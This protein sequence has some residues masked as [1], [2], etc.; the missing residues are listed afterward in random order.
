MRSWSLRLAFCR[1]RSPDFRC[2]LTSSWYRSPS[3]PSVTT[4]ARISAAYQSRLRVGGAGCQGCDGAGGG[5]AGG[6]YGSTG[7][8]GYG[9]GGSDGSPAAGGVSTAN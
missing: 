1:L 8:G 2:Q 5:A 6:E 9:G 7:G 3:P 4:T